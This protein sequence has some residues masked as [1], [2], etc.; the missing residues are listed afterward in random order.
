MKTAWFFCIFAVMFSM[1]SAASVINIANDGRTDYYT[2]IQ[3]ALNSV[4]ADGGTVIIGEG[5]FIISNNVEMFS[6]TYLRGIS[7]EKSVIK[8]QDFAAPWWNSSGKN[9][10]LIRATFTNNTKI[11]DI[12]LDGNKINQ[13]DDPLSSYGR[14]GIFMDAC[15][16]VTYDKVRVRNFQGYGFDPHGVKP[17]IWGKSLTITNCVSENNGW[18][19]FTLDQTKDIVCENNTAKGNGRHGFNIV[20]G[21]ANILLKNNYIKDNGFTYYDKETK[22]TGVGCGVMMQNNLEYGTQNMNVDQNIIISSAKAGICLNNVL[23]V[24]IS[25]NNVYNVPVFVWIDVS[26]NVSVKNNEYMANV[27]VGGGSSANE[28]VF[29]NN[30][31]IVTSTYPIEPSLPSGTPI[32]QEVL[33][34][35]SPPLNPQSPTSSPSPPGVMT[36]SSEPNVS[37]NNWLMFIGLLFSVMSSFR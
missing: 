28:T 31:N 2:I 19:G 4:K 36:S 33:S 29:D 7:M 5:E 15:N 16:N 21:S 10:G 1:S 3:D 26:K 17:S 25:G 13:K 12:T 18:D 6:N 11:S 35:P 22:S 8:L 34:S 37:F 30:T 27:T 14:F 32:K 24:E 9:A 20:T 23:N